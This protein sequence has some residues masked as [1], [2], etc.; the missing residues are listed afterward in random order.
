M[1]EPLSVLAPSG[2]WRSLPHRS[3]AAPAPPTDPVKIRIPKSEFPKQKAAAPQ[4]KA[5]AES[6]APLGGAS[7]A[8]GRWL[9]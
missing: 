8:R 4:A 7:R 9:P 6:G 3:D 5:R 1:A 2:C